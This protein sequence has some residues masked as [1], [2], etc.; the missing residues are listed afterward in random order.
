ME[1]VLCVF[2]Q[3]EHLHHSSVSVIT[4]LTDTLG[5]GPL[6]LSLEL[7]LLSTN[8]MILHPKPKRGYCDAVWCLLY[9]RTRYLHTCS[10][11]C[12]DIS[13]PSAMC[14]KTLVRSESCSG[15]RILSYIMDCLSLKLFSVLI[16][17]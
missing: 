17:P 5:T 12:V 7:L 8:C 4:I 6:S 2:Y 1:A 11:L 16:L 3:F 15:E 14:Q 10:I 9:R 13:W